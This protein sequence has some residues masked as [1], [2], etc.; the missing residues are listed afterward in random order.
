[1]DNNLSE[2]ENVYKVN[3]FY[4]LTIITR[5]EKEQEKYKELEQELIKTSIFF[6]TIANK[7]NDFYITPSA[8]FNPTQFLF[9]NIYNI[10][11]FNPNKVQRYQMNW[12]ICV[13]TSHGAYIK[14]TII[15]NQ[16]YNIDAVTKY[17]IPVLVDNYK[18]ILTG[19]MQ[20]IEP[21][22]TLAA[23]KYVR[24]LGGI[25]KTLSENVIESLESNITLKHGY[26]QEDVEKDFFIR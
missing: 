13:S 3:E 20:A 12:G 9:C 8:R 25:N 10:N 7:Y 4:G 24:D 6:L 5:N 19:K 1:M 17:C 21:V 18:K 26:T 16:I 15:F 11:K 23:S 2:Q 22:R 14:D